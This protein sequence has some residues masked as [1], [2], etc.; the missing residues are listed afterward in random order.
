MSTGNVTEAITVSGDTELER[1][2]NRSRMIGADPELVVHGGG[3]TSSK[4]RERD[5]LGRER[6][7]LRIKGSG[8]DLKTI[9]ADGFPGLFLDDLLALRE[10]AEM[11]D[12]AMVAYLAHCMVEPGSR[13]PSI[14]TLLHAFLPARFIDH[15]HADSVLAVLDSRHGERLAEEIWGADHLVVPYAKPGFD[16]ARRVREL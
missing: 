14:E 1:L 5:H 9:G 3:N 10:Q 12:E 13:R 16:L 4:T 11:S 15:T 8:T 2:V 6:A 7:V